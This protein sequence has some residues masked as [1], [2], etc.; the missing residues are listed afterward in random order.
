MY[1]HCYCGTGNAEM[2]NDAAVIACYQVSQEVIYIQDIEEMGTQLRIVG[3]L[4]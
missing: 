2:I 4:V 1:L 3:F